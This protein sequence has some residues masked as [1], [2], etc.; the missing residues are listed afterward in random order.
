MN[1]GYDLFLLPFS[2]VLMEHPN[3]FQKVGFF[4]ASL[5]HFIRILLCLLNRRH[6]AG[7]EN[8]AGIALMSLLGSK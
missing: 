5:L 7:G 2:L 8:E 6:C 4:L 1:D 3:P